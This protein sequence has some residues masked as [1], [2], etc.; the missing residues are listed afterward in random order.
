MPGVVGEGGS[1][2]RCGRLCLGGHGSGELGGY[3]VC[4]IDAMPFTLRGICSINTRR[5]RFDDSFSGLLSK[6]I[7]ARA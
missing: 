3:E 4:N 7:R 2:W 5:P 6:S 1:V